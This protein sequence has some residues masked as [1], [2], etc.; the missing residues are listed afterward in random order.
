MVWKSTALIH[1]MLVEKQLCKNILVLLAHPALQTSNCKNVMIIN[2][3]WLSNGSRRNGSIKVSSYIL[4][5]I[6]RRE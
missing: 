2:G 6:M 3:Y 5:F 1:G 4:V